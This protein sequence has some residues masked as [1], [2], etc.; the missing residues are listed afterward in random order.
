MHRI[1]GH[2]GRLGIPTRRVDD[3]AIDPGFI[4]QGNGLTRSERG[5]LPVGCVT[6]QACAPRVDL[7]VN[8]LHELPPGLLT[9]SVRNGS[10]TRWLLL[11]VSHAATID[12]G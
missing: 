9:P 7:S 6:R 10:R 12:P 11:M 1:E 5:D 4:H 3:G 2:L 8:N